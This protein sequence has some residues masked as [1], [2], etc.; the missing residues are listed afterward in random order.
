MVPAERL[1]EAQRRLGAAQ[2]RSAELMAS[3]LAIPSNTVFNA[4]ADGSMHG[5]CSLDVVLHA[6]IYN[7]FI[8]F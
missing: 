7:D 8:R 3:L 5:L 2:R 4:I 6:A 1:R